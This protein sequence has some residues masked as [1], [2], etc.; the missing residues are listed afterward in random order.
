MPETLRTASADFARGLIEEETHQKRIEA[1]RRYAARPKGKP[2]ADGYRRYSCPAGHGVQ[3]PLKANKVPVG[4][5]PVQIFPSKDLI[6]RRPKCCV[7]ESV[8]IPPE[9]GAKFFQSIP[10]ATEEWH[11]V[12]GALRNAVEGMNGYLKDSAFQGLA[13]PQRRRVRGVAAQSVLVTC[14]IVAANWRKID[15]FL[16]AVASVGTFRRPRPRPRRRTQSLE[17]RRPQ[18]FE[19]TG[20]RAPPNSA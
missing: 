2:D 17:N 1:R 19:P 10:F 13:N 15:S 5:T 4:I 14:Q 7:Q 3:C 11:R 12:F 16:Q 6:E 9:A 20:G 8:T 18:P